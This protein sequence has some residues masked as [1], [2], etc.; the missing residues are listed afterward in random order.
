MP[1]TIVPPRERTCERCGRHD[2]WDDA[3]ENWRIATVDG[4]KAAGNAHCIHEWDINGTY[5]PFGT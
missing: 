4:T 1:E 5:N 3:T 2:V